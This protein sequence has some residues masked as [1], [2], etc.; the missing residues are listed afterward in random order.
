MVFYLELK[1]YPLMWY[2]K[3][4]KKTTLVSYNGKNVFMAQDV[5]LRLRA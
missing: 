2:R 5:L 3:K 4:K 1:A